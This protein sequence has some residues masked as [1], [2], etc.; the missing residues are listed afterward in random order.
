MSLSAVPGY[1]KWPR[2]CFR[3]S[4]PVALTFCVNLGAINSSRSVFLNFIRDLYLSVKVFDASMLDMWLKI[5]DSL[6][7]G[8]DSCPSREGSPIGHSLRLLRY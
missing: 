6:G 5:S 8:F 7:F 1:R 4:N 2:H 3:R